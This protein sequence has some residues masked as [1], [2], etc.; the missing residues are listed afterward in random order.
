MTRTWNKADTALLGS[1]LFFL[2]SLGL[3]LH[4]PQTLWPEGLLM[5]SEAA[6]VGGVADWFA[7]TALFR[8]PLGFPYHTAI[9]P[10]RRDSFIHAIVIMVQKEFF[11]RRKLFRHIEKIHLL[12]ML[13]EF[14]HKK[15]TEK[16]LT[17][18]VL[19]FIRASFL[20][21]NNKKAISYLSARLKSL[22]LRE[23]PSALM[24]RFD[25][26]SKANGW[27]RQALTRIA[28]LLAREVSTEETRQSIRETLADLEREKIGDGFLSRL[29]EVTNTVNLD[30]GAELIQRHTC[31]VLDELGR[32]GSPL[33]ENATALLHDCLSDMRQDDELL[34]LARELQERLAQELPI[35]ETLARLFQGMRRHFQMDLNRAVDPI[36]EHMPAFYTQLQNILHLE[37]QHM[38]F[39]VEER[40]E[41]QKIIAKV[42]YDLLARSALHAQTLVGVIVN[43]VLS[44]LTDDELNHLIYD[45][46]EEDLLWIRVNGSL[47]GGCIGLLL[48][49]C[50]N[51]FR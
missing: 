12:P 33:Q 39:L 38:L 18:T 51:I 25:T 6:L 30:E 44:R 35:D 7:V 14:L 22:I 31:H 5:V 10:R 3:H 50:M 41:L 27:D 11:S 49:V 20:R 32:A 42:L 19:H 46:V 43:N 26:L 45:K 40:T 36:E 34:H 2:L 21:K 13:Q 24:S 37:Y 47:V 17:G 16:Q 48:F 9:L 15:R 1:F 23:D 4:F 29:L 8:K 28:Q